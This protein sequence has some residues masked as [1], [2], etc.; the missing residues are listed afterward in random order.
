[1]LLTA[2]GAGGETPSSSPAT[3]E[4]GEIAAEPTTAVTNTPAQPPEP[5]PSP[6]LPPNFS[7]SDVSFYYDEALL[8][9]ATAE[10]IPA[11]LVALD[12][13][14]MYLPGVPDFIQIVFEQPGTGARPST[15]LI[16]PIRTPAGEIYAE[17]P[18]WHRQQLLRLEELLATGAPEAGADET[19]HVQVQAFQSGAGVR[20]I[21]DSPDEFTAV[22]P[23]GS[24]LYYTFDGVTNDGIYF[25][26]LV[27]PVDLTDSVTGKRPDSREQRARLL[28]N[29]GSGQF[30]PALDVLDQMIASLMVGPNASTAS[31][32]PTNPPGC[33]ND[34]T[35]VDDVTVPDGTL[36]EIG[37][38]ITKTWRL[39]NSGTC[40]WTAEY[41]TGFV[42]GTAFEQS[43]G[44]IAD[45][46]PPGSETDVSIMLTAPANPGTYKGIWRLRTHDGTLF[47]T[48]FYVEVEV[49]PPP[50]T[51]NG[52]GR[53][54]GSIS[55]PAGGLP[56]MTIY[57]QRTD[58]SERYA[59]ET[60]E[61]WNRYANEIPVG[62]Y[63]VFA[64]VN[65]DT[66][67]SG[68][69]YTQFVVCGQTA[70]C[71][72]HSLVPVIVREHRMTRNID[73]ADWYAPAGSFPIP[74]EPTPTTP[75][76]EDTPEPTEP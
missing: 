1:M 31:T 3:A 36:V 41:T 44:T 51:L 75:P 10:K 9:R 63:Y 54:E 70:S 43:P 27:Y 24:E 11:Q 21:T 71:T 35:F 20:R 19:A 25:I 2:C 72:D 28:E 16:Q 57:F 76:S 12:G 33:V 46:T 73:I 15:M 34:A 58:G 45:I 18:E 56:V 8:G 29:D 37:D 38:T 17:T 39:R 64:H 50:N 53:V 67:E 6:T 69:G 61:G 74:D 40:I 14:P 60:Q 32:L 62:E 59:L 65:G 26:Q 48:T 7:F 13:S 66:S 49:P 52:Y 55:Y 22:A 68:G 42:E 23:T 4:S 47:G 30:K 5:P